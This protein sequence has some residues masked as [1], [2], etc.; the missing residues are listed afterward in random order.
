MAEET[1]GSPPHM[2]PHS[3][4]CGI[5]CYAQ[6]GDILSIEHSPTAKTVVLCAEG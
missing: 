2:E 4:A 1:K 3:Q 5:F 6:T